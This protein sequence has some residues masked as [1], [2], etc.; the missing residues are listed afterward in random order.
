MAR[1]IQ[2]KNSLEQI[3]WELLLGV[4]LYLP[5]LASVLNLDSASPAF[6]ILFNQHGPQILESVMEH[7]L[8]VEIRGLIRLTTYIRSLNGKLPLVSLNVFVNHHLS[9]TKTSAAVNLIPTETHPSVLRGILLTAVKIDAL[10]EACLVEFMRRCLASRPTR[11]V[12]GSSKD[13]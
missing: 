4:A 10:T 3:P 9:T 6:A 5:D 8:P 7:C 11:L 13:Q 12:K 1:H 2:W